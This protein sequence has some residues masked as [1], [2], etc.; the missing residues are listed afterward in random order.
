M[1]KK[2]VYLKRWILEN[3][4]KY[5]HNNNDLRNG[6]KF[7]EKSKFYVIRETEK[8]VYIN[9][10]GELW[11]PKSALIKTIETTEEKQCIENKIES[12][13]NT[14]YDFN[15]KIEYAFFIADINEFINIVNKKNDVT[16]EEKTDY[17]NEIFEYFNTSYEEVEN[18]ISKN[19][20]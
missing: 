10:N 16:I 12:L 6:Y 1:I 7:N 15:D 17:I 13:K 5:A 18:F 8:A 9:A 14:N 19:K 4:N 11:I 3:N 20:K 2:Y